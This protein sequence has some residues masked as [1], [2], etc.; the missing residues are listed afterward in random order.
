MSGRPK[1]RSRKYRARR[2]LNSKQFW[3]LVF[4]LIRSGQNLPAISKAVDVP[5]RTLWGWINESEENRQR[6]EESKKEQFLR[7]Q[8]EISK[9]QKSIVNEYLN[10][11]KKSSRFLKV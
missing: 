3:N 4:D 8:E 6:Y 1:Q 11:E 10:V 9:F 5:Y 2:L 7:I